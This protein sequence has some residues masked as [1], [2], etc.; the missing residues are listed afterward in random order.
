ML[1]ALHNGLKKADPGYHDLTAMMGIEPLEVTVLRRGAFGD[2]YLKKCE[3]GLDLAQRKP[4]RVNPPEEAI[5]ELVGNGRVV[6]LPK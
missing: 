3:K 4:P 5:R 6:S 1:P 2:Y